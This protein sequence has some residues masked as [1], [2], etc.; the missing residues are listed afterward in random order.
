MFA[1][2]SMVSAVVLGLG[3][4]PVL[5]IGAP[6]PGQDEGVVYPDDASATPFVAERSAGGPERPGLDEATLEPAVAPEVPGAGT[7]ASDSGT[8]VVDMGGPERSGPADAT[9]SPAMGR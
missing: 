8:A 2:R 6:A 3:A 9:Y 4:M 1:R 5:G 7:Q